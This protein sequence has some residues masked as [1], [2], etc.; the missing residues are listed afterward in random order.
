MSAVSDKGVDPAALSLLLRRPT[1]AS[2]VVLDLGFGVIAYFAAYWLRF[3]DNQLPAFLPGAVS[4]VPFVVGGQ[5]LALLAVG[6]YARR[7]RLDWLLRVVSG[8]VMGTV[9]ASV[10]LGITV[11]FEGVSRGAFAADVVLLTTTA[12]G[13]RSAWVVRTRA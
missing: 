8:V 4:T 10:L 9:G 2:S 13:W 7:Q 6:A 12:I 3:R 5:I 1:A 11:G